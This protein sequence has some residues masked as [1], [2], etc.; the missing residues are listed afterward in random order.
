MIEKEKEKVNLVHSKRLQWQP[1]GAVRVQERGATDD[2]SRR[3]GSIC[4]FIVIYTN[5]FMKYHLVIFKGPT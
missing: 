2:V 1:W 4:N 5:M 3:R